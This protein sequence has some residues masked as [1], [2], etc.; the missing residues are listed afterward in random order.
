VAIT[1]DVDDPSLA[2]LLASH[3]FREARIPVLI[4]ASAPNPEQL[5][6]IARNLERFDWVICAS[7]RSVRAMA[8]ARGSRWP[9]DQRT[10]AVG[11]AT[12]AALVDAGAADP[13]QAA[14]FNARAL[15]DT[16]R[17]LDNWAGRRVLVATV[18]GGR[19]DV[20]D[21]LRSA[22][23]EVT[24]IEAYA[25]AP[26]PAD[27]IRGDWQAAQPDAVIFGSANI[28]RHLIAAIGLDAVRSLKA[29]VAIGPT[30]ADAL[31]ALGVTAEIAPQAT[32]AAAVAH[33]AAL[34]HGSVTP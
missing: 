31:S 27:R 15:W 16:L 8:A 7:V 3:G 18:A 34:A 32:F 24:E 23:A 33:L 29:I 20:I 28:A 10:A 22:G 12:A 6:A 26:R 19:R 14:T 30:T 25:M 21:A 1:R 5:I 17:P 4:E 13:V 9:G 11:A 2:A